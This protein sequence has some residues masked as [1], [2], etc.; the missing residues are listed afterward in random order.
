MCVYIYRFANAKY[1]RI[2][3]LATYT[4][5]KGIP[6][7]TALS[8]PTLECDSKSSQERLGKRTPD[9]PSM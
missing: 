2:G 4:E 8:R 9:S 7:V 1:H 3:S 5:A 6:G